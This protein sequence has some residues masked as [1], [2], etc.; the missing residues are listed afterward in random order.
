VEERRGRRTAGAHLV[1]GRLEE[2]LNLEA[3]RDGFQI[4]SRTS[5]QDSAAAR[6]RKGV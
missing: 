3:A 5:G 2:P 1:G 6:T 4:R